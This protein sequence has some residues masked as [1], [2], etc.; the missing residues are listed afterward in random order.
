[1]T[2][3]PLDGIRVLDF[4]RVLAGPHCGRMLADLGADVIKVEPPA[5]DL[6]RYAYPRAG[7]MALYFVQQNTGKRNLSLDLDQPA[8]ADLLLRLCEHTDV[9]LENFRPGVMDRMGIGYDAMAAR[10]P[11]LVYASIT[12]YGQD[13]PWRDRRAYAVVVQAEMGF[14]DTAVT[15]RPSGDPTQDAVSHADTYAGLECLAAILAALLQ[16]ERTGEGQHID[17]AMAETLLC[18]NDFA[19]VDVSGIPLG[20]HV[21]SLAP[22]FSPVLATGDGRRVLIAGD[23]AGT[24]TFELYCAAMERPDL[25]DDERFAAL[26]ARRR[27]RDELLAI[28]GEWVATFPAPEPLEACLA[29]QRI[30]MGIVRST[31]EAAT[32]EWA[33]ARGALVDVDDR[34]GGTVAIPN[35]PWRFSGAASGV[36]GK[37]AWRGEHNREILRD[38]LGLGD[39]ELIDLEARG[40]LSSR[41]PTA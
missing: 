12:G 17:V 32:S 26:P 8:A 10:N 37:P 41:V 34:R 38:V 23:P 24:G 19:H 11:R 7:S 13:G 14:V 21:P 18:V 9:V 3:A 22:P 5:G 33:Q 31:A 27:H 28:V 20:D 30:A 15:Y 39:D 25:L 2:A 36:R 35:S 40:V 29:R 4:S 16:R 1:V 6:T